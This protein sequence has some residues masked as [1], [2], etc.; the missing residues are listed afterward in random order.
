YSSTNTLLKEN[1]KEYITDLVYQ[2]RLMKR[3][4]KTKPIKIGPNEERPRNILE[5]QMNKD[6]TKLS[7]TS[8]LRNRDNK[9]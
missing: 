2:N 4:R 1:H 9:T 7:Q 6:L 5:R 3:T 8:E